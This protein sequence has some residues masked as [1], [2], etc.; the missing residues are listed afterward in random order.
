MGDA[1]E[2]LK[3]IYFC[4]IT[5]GYFKI[6][7]LNTIESKCNS[8]LKIIDF[9]KAKEKICNDHNLGKFQ[10]SDALIII[11]ENE[12]IDLI[13]VKKLKESINHRINEN[14]TD[15]EIDKNIDEIFNNFNLFGKAFDSIQLIQILMR[16]KYVNKLNEE[17]RI[18]RN[19]IINFQKNIKVYFI[20][21]VDIEFCS[22]EDIL[23]SLE[24]L[25][26]LKIN[27]KS[28]Y[29]KIKKAITNEFNRIL[30]NSIVFDCLLM[31]FNE[32]DDYY[33]KEFGTLDLFSK[34]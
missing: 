1:K 14:L 25:D 11:K 12:R 28:V 2:T 29:D 4:G 27:E 18:K 5:L 3:K 24:V 13:E 26:Y 30:N 15:K 34:I 22:V 31:S 23:A 20:L 21:L 6:V 16:S 33:I 32:I 19:D 17:V 9:D 8:K 7:E 10:S